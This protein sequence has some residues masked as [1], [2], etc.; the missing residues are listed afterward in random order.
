[1]GKVVIH[2]FKGFICVCH[3]LKDSPSSQY[4]YKTWFGLTVKQKDIL[5]VSAVR[6]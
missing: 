4:S 2:E 6:L 3:S 5:F 1:V